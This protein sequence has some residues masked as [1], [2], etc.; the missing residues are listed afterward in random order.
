MWAF[1]AVVSA[2]AGDYATAGRGDASGTQVWSKTPLSVVGTDHLAV[3][4]DLV[5]T[6]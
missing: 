4:A 5:V 2:A 1:A 3:V 6:R